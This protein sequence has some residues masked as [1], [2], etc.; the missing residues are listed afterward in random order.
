MKTKLVRLSL[1]M[2][3]MMSVT[4]V[5]AVEVQP[6]ATTTW[7][8]N[9]FYENDVVSTITTATGNLGQLY[10]YD[11]L[12]FC[13]GDSNTG[14][15]RSITATAATSM[16]NS[17][18]PAISDYTPFA[19]GDYVG[20]K[21]DAASRTSLDVSVDNTSQYMLVGVK[22]IVAGKLYVL[23]NTKSSGKNAYLY[24]GKTAKDTKSRSTSDWIL[25]SCD[26][27]ANNRYF[28]GCEETDWILYGVKFVPTSDA[29]DLSQ[30]NISV[31]VKNG[32]ATFS[33]ACNYKL[34]SGYKAY[35]VSAVDDTKATL[36]NIAHIPSN[37]GVILVGDDG[38]TEVITMKNIRESDITDADKTNAA[39]NK[40]IANVGEYALP[41]SYGSDY[42]YTLA[43]DGGP[44]FKHSTGSGSVSANKA[45]LRTT[46]NAPTEAHGL[47][48]VFENETTGIETIDNSHLKV[49]NY[50]N[51]SGQRVAQPTRGLYIVNGKKVVIK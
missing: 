50:F 47:D 36:T 30:H 2:L 26:V 3:A 15:T 46:V 37:T 1:A 44:V 38:N 19:K 27:T 43:Y 40:L 35:V 13:I 11:K 21:F 51:L 22:P 42:N 41:A 4:G 17:T 49:D 33:S 34:P 39:S 45:Y 23:V 8:F 6:R 16:P 18:A 24:E 48:F 14:R 28:I 10:V 9:Q 5:K 32:Y 31:S 20:I 29:T 12:Y 25:L 7:L